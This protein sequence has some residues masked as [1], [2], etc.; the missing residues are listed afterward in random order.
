[1]KMEKKIFNKASTELKQRFDSS[2][3]C[4]CEI[5]D[6]F[7]LLSVYFHYLNMTYTTFKNTFAL[8]NSLILINK[9]GLNV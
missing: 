2:W 9:V 5:S 1:M 8:K 3:H 6:I 4:I 7:L